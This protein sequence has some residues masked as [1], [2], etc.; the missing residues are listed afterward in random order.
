MRIKLPLPGFSETPFA[1]DFAV[2]L[3]KYAEDETTFFSFAL[4]RDF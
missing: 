1:I 3:Q 2:P 4:T